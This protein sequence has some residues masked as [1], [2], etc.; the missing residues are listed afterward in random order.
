MNCTLYQ[1]LP[2]LVQDQSSMIFWTSSRVRFSRQSRALFCA[3]CH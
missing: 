3:R 2:S 1:R